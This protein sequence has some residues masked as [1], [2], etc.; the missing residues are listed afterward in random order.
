MVAIRTEPDGAKI[1]LNSQPLGVSPVETDMSN[2]DFQ[3]YVVEIS[4]SGYKTLTATL[5]KEFKVGAFVV[6]LLVWWPELLWAYGPKS[7]QTFELEP[8]N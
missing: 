3:D 6:G 2:F 7:V 4:K 1:K 5:Q 8:A